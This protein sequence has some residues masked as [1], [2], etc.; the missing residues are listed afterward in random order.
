M[1]RSWWIEDMQTLVWLRGWD[2][3]YDARDYHITYE[4]YTVIGSK[5]CPRREF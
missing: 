3:H 1:E 4:Q 2:A 5:R